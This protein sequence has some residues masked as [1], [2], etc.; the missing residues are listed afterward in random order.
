MKLGEI[1]E[2]KKCKLLNSNGNLIMDKKMKQH[3]ETMT[4]EDCIDDNCE[5]YQECWKGGQN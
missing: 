2:N 5:F 1:I 3:L 4:E